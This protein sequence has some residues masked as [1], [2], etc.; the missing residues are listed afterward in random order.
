MVVSNFDSTQ[1]SP[2][3]SLKIPVLKPVEIR[4]IP[5][6]GLGGEAQ[7]PTLKNSLSDSGLLL[8]FSTAIL[9]NHILYFNV[10][11]SVP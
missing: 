10:Q 3:E 2:G 7:A 1:E 9:D 11:I 4:M 8:I 5:G 6:A